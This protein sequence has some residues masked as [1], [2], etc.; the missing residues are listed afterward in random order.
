MF[1]MRTLLS[2]DP[3]LPLEVR[4]ALAGARGI[5]REELARL[6]VNAC[7][8]SELL[9]DGYGAEPCED[10]VADPVGQRCDLR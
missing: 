2:S 3:F 9:D 4:E 1:S 7:E 5:A 6:G 8:A 10:G